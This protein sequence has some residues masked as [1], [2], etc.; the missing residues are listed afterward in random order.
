MKTLLLL[1]LGVATALLAS[2]C[3][4]SEH[5]GYYGGAYDRTYEG[6]GHGFE[7]YNS[8]NGYPAPAPPPH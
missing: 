5:H 4:S 3:E 6:Y 8:F 1:S 7:G 2:A